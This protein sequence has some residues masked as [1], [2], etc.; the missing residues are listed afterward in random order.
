MLD[1]TQFLVKE[2]LGVLKLTDAYDILNPATGAKVVTLDA[3]RKK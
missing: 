1:L 3:F 2:H